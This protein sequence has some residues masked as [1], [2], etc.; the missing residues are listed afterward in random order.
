MKSIV[1]VCAGNTCRSPAA[2]AL[3]AALVE[4]RE[5]WWVESAGIRAARGAPASRE[6]V[7]LLAERGIDLSRH[8]SKLLEDLP[9]DAFGLALVMEEEHK[10]SLLARCPGLAGRVFLLGEMS[11]GKEEVPDPFGG[12]LEDYQNMLGRLECLILAGMQ[13]IQ[14]RLERGE[15]RPEGDIS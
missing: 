1:F 12:G 2:A 10:R 6:L 13:G 7:S 15:T 3:F 11:G 4:E 9:L 8:R 5:A 14:A